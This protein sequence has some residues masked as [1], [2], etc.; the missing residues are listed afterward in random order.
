[1]KIVFPTKEKKRPKIGIG[2]WLLISGELHAI[3][4]TSFGKIKLMAFSDELETAINRNYGSSKPDG[5]QWTQE[6]S[7]AQNLSD[8][9]LQQLFADVPEE[10]SIEVV[11]VEIHIKFKE[12][13]PQLIAK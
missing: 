10:A 8:E 2:T 9:V 12:S 1:M 13:G 4:Q 3:A 11:D 6:N 5:V 7:T